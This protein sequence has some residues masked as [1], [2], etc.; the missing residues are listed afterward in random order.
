[1]SCDIV[2]PVWNKKEL[3]E[4]CINSIVQHTTYPYRVVAVDNG[5]EEPTKA[6][7]KGLRERKD[8]Q[9]QLI[10]NE[11]N[12]G[13]TAAGNQGMRAS[14]S[15][16]VLILDN[17]TVVTDGWLSELVRIAE[18]D[19]KIGIASPT[20]NSFGAYKKK[21]QTHNEY[22]AE[23]LSP[24]GGKYIETTAAGGFAFMIKREV[25]EKIGM[26][27]E[28][29]SPGYFED[30]EYSLR[31]IKNGYICAIAEGSYIFHDEHRSFKKSKETEALIA[32]NREIFFKMYG[33]MERIVYILTGE[34]VDRY[35]KIEP[36]TYRF[37]KGYSW[38]NIWLKEGVLAPKT[39]YHTNIR[40]RDI[41]K[42][43][44]RLKC[45]WRI[46]KKRKK[47][48]TKVYSDD[49]ILARWLKR[50]SWLHSAEINP[51]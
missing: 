14:N 28:R 4:R 39:R 22:A 25:I 47:P 10:R 27:D 49:P 23:L 19:P 46:I 31:A 26:W 9:F 21:G 45:L 1:M 36:D 13:N 40:K 17:D 30:T 5:S 34:S 7:L 12:L 11:K 32:R 35:D 37:A 42:H 2:I 24:K 38:I 18:S 6:Y 15:K 44:F 29:F 8:F 20:S 48:F 51:I 43:N 3:T 50:L 16:Y 41:P 33:R